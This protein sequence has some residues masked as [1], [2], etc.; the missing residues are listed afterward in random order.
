MADAAIADSN[1]AA[2]VLSVDLTDSDVTISNTRAEL[3]EFTSHCPGC[4][5]SGET[6]RI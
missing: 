1:G 2:D 5:Q 3:A 4:K 6:K